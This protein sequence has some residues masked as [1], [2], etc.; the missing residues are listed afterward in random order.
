[1]HEENGEVKPDGGFRWSIAKGGELVH[2]RVY[3]GMAILLTHDCEIENDHPP[4]H[5]TL[6]MVR[7]ITE[8]GEVDRP[9]ILGLRKYSA[10]PLPPQAAP[11]AMALSFVDFRRLTTVRPGVLENSIRHGTLSEAMRRGLAEHF[12]DFLFRR[13]E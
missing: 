4:G 5:R 9:P 3:M 6:A 2:A 11:P 13:Q 7:P 8:I 1:M 12:W 10:F